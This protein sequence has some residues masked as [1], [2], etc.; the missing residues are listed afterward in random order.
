[1]RIKNILVLKVFLLLVH[2]FFFI[3]LC[4]RALHAR[5]C[6]R[7]GWMLELKSS[8]PMPSAWAASLLWEV[9]MPMTITATGKKK[10]RNGL[11][12][13]AGWFSDDFSYFHRV[14]LAERGFI[15]SYCSFLSHDMCME[16]CVASSV[17]LINSLQWVW[18]LFSLFSPCLGHKGL[19]HAVLPEQ[20]HQLRGRLRY[21]LRARLHGLR[22]KCS[23]WGRGGIW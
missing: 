21:L 19:P 18:C 16:V 2:L 14:G 9:T 22:T 13:L 15:C 8:S 11:R 5:P 1:M 23:N 6:S 17:G 12:L 20:R 3:V 7:C 4:A 10:K